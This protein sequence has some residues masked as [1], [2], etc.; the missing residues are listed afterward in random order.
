MR[1]TF[2]FKHRW[3]ERIGR[4]LADVGKVYAGCDFHTQSCSTRGYI[5]HENDE[6]GIVFI[7]FR[8]WLVTCYQRENS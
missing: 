2:H 3:R 5:R 8:E 7:T 6:E 1:L 4:P